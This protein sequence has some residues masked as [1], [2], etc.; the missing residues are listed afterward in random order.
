MLRLYKRR[1]MLRLYRKRQNLASLQKCLFFKKKPMHPELP[2]KEEPWEVEQHRYIHRITTR[3]W[4]A[5]IAEAFDLERGAWYTLKALFR[6]PAR[7][8]LD[9]LG[10]GRFKYVPPFRLLVVSTALVLLL[11]NWVSGF[12][13]FYVGF[14]EGSD[15]IEEDTIQSLEQITI[16][17]FNLLLWLYLPFAAAT[18]WLFNRKSGFTFAEHMVLQTNLLSL[19]NLLIPLFFIYLIIPRPEALFIYFIPVVIY[20]IVTYKQFYQKSWVR[21]ILEMVLIFIISYLVYTLV[22]SLVVAL[23]LLVIEFAS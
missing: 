11:V 22:I 1:K 13:Q 7:L 16:N 8:T 9:Y 19:T 2:D 5:N 17:Y 10:R 21:G 20:N 3:R 4:L 12:E 14:R 15:A 23:A 6:S 18:V